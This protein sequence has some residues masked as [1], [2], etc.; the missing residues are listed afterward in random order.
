MTLEAR[1]ALIAEAQQ[2][3]EDARLQDTRKSEAPTP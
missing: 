2:L 1:Q 3:L